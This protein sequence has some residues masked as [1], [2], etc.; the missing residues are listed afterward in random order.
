MRT[1]PGGGGGGGHSELRQVT[2]RVASGFFFSLPTQ[3]SRPFR[4]TA[5]LS[6]FCLRLAAMHSGRR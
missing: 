4:P 3:T 1:H 5:L 2:L 6:T